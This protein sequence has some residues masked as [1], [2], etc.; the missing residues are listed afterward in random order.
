MAIYY[1]F[2]IVIFCDDGRNFIWGTSRCRHFDNNGQEKVPEAK[3]CTWERRFGHTSRSCCPVISFRSRII[4]DR[5]TVCNCRAESDKWTFREVHV[6]LPV[7]GDWNVCL[8]LPEK[9]VC[10]ARTRKTASYYVVSSEFEV[11]PG[12]HLVLECS[13]IGS[14]LQFCSASQRPIGR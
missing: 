14:R 11:D 3:C 5:V 9:P 6:G 2:M 7:R 4:W 10:E 13:S 12:R 1:P 8:Q